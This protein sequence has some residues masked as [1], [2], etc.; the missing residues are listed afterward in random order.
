[1]NKFDLFYQEMNML[2][3]SPFEQFAI[4]KLINFKIWV[5]D[6]SLTNSAIFMI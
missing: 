3:T 5:F 6:F 4:I 2:S 1:M